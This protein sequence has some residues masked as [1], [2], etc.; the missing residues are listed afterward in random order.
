MASTA[1]FSKIERLFS[2]LRSWLH[3]IS[4]FCSLR[5]RFRDLHLALEGQLKHDVLR[6]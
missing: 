6:K 5:T 1:L 2:G 4:L 3:R